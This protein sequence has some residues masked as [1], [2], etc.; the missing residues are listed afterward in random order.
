MKLYHIDRSCTLKEGDTI[1]YITNLSVGKSYLNDYC[2][3]VIDKEYSEGISL[4]G[5]RY[6]LD[7]YS[8]SSYVMD[9]IFEY[10]RRLNYPDK[11][12]RY[13]SFF[14]FD[15]E[16]LFDFIKL[17][18]LDFEFIKVYEF[19]YDYCEKYNLNLIRG[20]GQF[21]TIVH[22]KYYWENKDDFNEERKPLY[23]YL[24]KLPVKIKKEVSLEELRKQLKNEE[25]EANNQDK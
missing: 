9:I 7:D 17:K 5:K 1:D 18:S 13:Q 22:S 25:P 10:E 20:W 8:S 15:L 16:G 6:F 12:S 3:E 2:K 23:E 11:L 4:H 19:D 21:D 14:A 24:V